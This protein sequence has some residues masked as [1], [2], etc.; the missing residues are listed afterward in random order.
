MTTTI[1][2]LETQIDDKTGQPLADGLVYFYEVGTSTPKTTYADTG[3]TTENTHPVVL[4]GDG[5][6]PSVNFD[7]QAKA[8]ITKGNGEQVREIAVLGDAEQIL[9]FAPWK[10]TTTYAARAIVQGENFEYYLSIIPG[11]IGNNPV[12]SPT[13]WMRMEVTNIYNQYAAFSLDDV[14]LYGNR[15]WVSRQDGNLDNR[16]DLSPDWWKPMDVRV[17]L[18][19]VIKTADFNAEAGRQYLID[20]TADVFDIT[21]PNEPPNGSPIKISDIGGQCGVRPVTLLRNGA[22]II[23]LAEDHAIDIDYF[24]GQLTYITGRG[25]VYA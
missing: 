10:S 18:D 19:T 17:W 22:N 12:D 21:L 24:T 14:V 15:L 13:A 16:P 8:V 2:S 11:N 6:L 3:L 5:S 1:V 9:A 4:N 23:D 25:W 20:S 7:G